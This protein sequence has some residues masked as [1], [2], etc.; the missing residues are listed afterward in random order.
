[1]LTIFC[2][3]KTIKSITT[4]PYLDDKFKLKPFA[5]HRGNDVRIAREH[6]GALLHK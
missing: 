3:T 5:K 6:T 1:M 2:S 4:S